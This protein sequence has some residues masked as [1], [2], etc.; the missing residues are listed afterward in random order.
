M[1]L[2]GPFLVGLLGC[3]R[4]VERLLLRWRKRCRSLDKL[5]RALRDSWRNGFPHPDYNL[6]YKAPDGRE[7]HVRRLRHVFHQ[8]HKCQSPHYFCMD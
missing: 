1:G 7:L 6:V 8:Q 2:V 4:G 3:R 5:H